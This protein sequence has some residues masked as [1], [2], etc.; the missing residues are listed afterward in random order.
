MKKY[1]F[2][3]MTKCILK[4]EKIKIAPRVHQGVHDDTTDIILV[5]V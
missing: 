2:R 3:R 1:S 4:I 5:K